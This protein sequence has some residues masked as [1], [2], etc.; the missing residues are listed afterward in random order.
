MLLL[1]QEQLLL[2]SS[3][4]FANVEQ[5]GVLGGADLGSPVCSL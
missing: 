3:K 1:L 4:Y 5:L 2:E